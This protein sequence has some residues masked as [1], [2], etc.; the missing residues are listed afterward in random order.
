VVDDDHTAPGQ[1]SGEAH[2]AAGRRQH[3]LAGTRG[4]V[5]PAVPGAP[6]LVGR[7]ESGDHAQRSG[8]WPSGRRWQS[9]VAEGDAV[10]A[11]EQERRQRDGCQDPSSSHI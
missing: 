6:A 2:P 3:R 10:A 4:Q 7:V 11:A 1:L 8:E 9:R 5:D